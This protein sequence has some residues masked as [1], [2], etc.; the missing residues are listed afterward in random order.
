MRQIK[1][2]NK[3]PPG[4]Y[5]EYVQPESNLLF[6]HHSRMWLAHEVKAHRQAMG[7]PV[8]PN[9]EVEIDE[10]VCKRQPHICIDENERN[11][12]QRQRLGWAE[13]VDGTETLFRHFVAGSPLVSQEEAESRA[14]VCAGCQYNVSFKKPCGGLCGQ[15]AT[16]VNKVVGARLVSNAGAINSCA[17]CGCYLNAAVWLPIEFQRVNGGEYPSWCWKQEK[18]P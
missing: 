17:L 7:Y 2:P 1:D 18:I 3:T 8:G 14:R 6:R 4:G 9:F 12:R 15:L 5:F 13:V 10:G 16:L 11:F